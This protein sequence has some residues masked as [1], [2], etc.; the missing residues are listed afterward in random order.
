[1]ATL[2]VTTVTT[3]NA[4]TDHIISTGNTAGAKIVIN[5][6]GNGMTFYANSSNVAAF[7]AWNANG[8]TLNV[9][10][11]LNL[12]SAAG[13]D[14]GNLAVIEIDASQNTYQQIVIQN[15]NSG[16]NASGDLI[17][18]NDSGNDTVG[19][20]DL[21][22]NSSTYSNATYNI[23]AAGDA[24]LYASN[25][26]LTV[27]TVATGKDIVFHANGITTT[28]EKFRIAATGN[29]TVAS[30]SFT[31][32]TS[33]LAA[34]GYTTLPNG[35]KMNWGVIICNTVSN[36]VFTSAFTTNAISISVTPITA[37]IYI[38]ANTV[39]VPV[40]NNTAAQIRSLSTTTTATVYFMAIGY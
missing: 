1:M 33:T 4:T 21:G 38:T 14:F 36:A 16:T 15:A 40:I 8:S 2:S 6:S 23:G 19:Y 12:G 11:K 30:N 34:N 32:G 3:G 28:A 10:T 37:S 13:Y 35:M 26:A 24:Y 39:Y 17:I 7:T 31:L 20:V 29:V 27:G 25:G 5:S 9:P 22:I 18:T